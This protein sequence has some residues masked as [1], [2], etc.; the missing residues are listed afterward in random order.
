MQGQIQ[1]STGD[2]AEGIQVTLLRRT[3][4]DGRVVWQTEANAK[5]NVEGVYRFGELSDGLYAVYTEPTMDSDAA[6]NLVETGSG[7]KV[8]RDGYASTFYPDARDLAG[9][10]KIHV[11]GGEQAQA[12]IALTLEPFHSVTAT[13]TMPKMRCRGG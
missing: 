6:T 13:V 12:N 10:A 1:L 8:E 3:V 9:A 4:Q 11:A 7:N 2:V 5:T